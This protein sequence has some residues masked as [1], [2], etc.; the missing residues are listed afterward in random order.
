M[1]LV[2]IGGYG[3]TNILT[4]KLRKIYEFEEIKI[5]LYLDINKSYELIPF[6]EVDFDAAI[7]TLLV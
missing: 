3:T 7:Q 5:I 2:C 1:I 4:Y 6:Q